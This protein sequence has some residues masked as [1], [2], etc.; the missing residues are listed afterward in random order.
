MG[1]RETP[2]TS[3]RVCGVDAEVFS[4]IFHCWS[5]NLLLDVVLSPDSLCTAAQCLLNIDLLLR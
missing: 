2:A 1:I 3:F 5:W 4:H